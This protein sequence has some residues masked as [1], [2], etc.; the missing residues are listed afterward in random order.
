MCLSIIIP[1]L[2]EAKSLPATLTNVMRLI[3][4]AYET[5]VVDGGST[6]NTLETAQQYPVKILQTDKACRALQMNVGAQAA[7]GD[8]LC[9]LHA[10]TL[11][12]Q[13]LVAIIWQTLSDDSLVLAGFTSIMKGQKKI[14]RLTSFLNFTKTYFI[15]LIYRP[16]RFFLKGLR[17]LFGDQ[18]MFCRKKNFW[19]VKGFN[20]Q[21]T[22]MEEADLCLRMNQLG[23]IKQIQRHV[24]SSDRRL[25]QWGFLKSYFI[26]VSICILWILGVSNRRL[27]QFYEDIR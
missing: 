1:T 11:V 13:D 17:L 25:A 16:N 10:D 9:F 6:D 4:E 26:W 24:V 3:P 19:A 12:P 7:T 2:N 8:Y 20:E 21:T 15:P 18:V 23:R 14:R 22:I 5:I 27:K